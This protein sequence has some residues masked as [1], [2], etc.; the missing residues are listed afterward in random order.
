M[1]PTTECDNHPFA[2]EPPYRVERYPMGIGDPP[3][4]RAV[5]VRTR[6][7]SGE[8]LTEDEQGV[9]AYV[10]YLE[11]KV[12]DLSEQLTEERAAAADAPPAAPEAAPPGEPPAPKKR[13]G[14]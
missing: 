3:P 11:A 12:R 9:W 10:E 7:V 6:G 8:L 2:K 14:K 4:I 13:K 1:F 5:K